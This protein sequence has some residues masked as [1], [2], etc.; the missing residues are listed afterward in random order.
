MKASKVI[1]SIKIE[2]DKC[3]GCRSCEVCCSAYHAEPRYSN[4]NPFKSRIRIFRD[5]LQD[6]YLPIISGHY[7][8]K[9]CD[10]R[11]KVVINGKDYEECNFCRAS[12]PARDI[13]WDPDTSEPLVCDGCGDPVP[14]GGPLCVQACP[15]E[16]LVYLP[17]RVE[18]VE[19]V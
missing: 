18:E 11:Y 4:V 19:V 14:E 15:R 1:K 5:E 17:E 8:E 10:V 16:A 3:T 12:C 7:A 13:F 2:P 9:E 6:V